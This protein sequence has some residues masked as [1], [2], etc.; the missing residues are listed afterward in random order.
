MSAWQSRSS[1]AAFALLVGVAATAAAQNKAPANKP[2]P[3]AAETPAAGEEAA[4]AP[5]PQAEAPEPEG[6]SIAEATLQTGETQAELKK[7]E[8]RLEIPPTVE[9]VRKDVYTRVL[10]LQDARRAAEQRLGSGEVQAKGLLDLQREWQLRQKDTGAWRA[11]LRDYGSEIDAVLQALDALAK[12]W[13][14]TRER[15]IEAEADSVVERVDAIL[16]EIAD[17]EQIAR[18]RLAELIDIQDRTTGMAGVITGVLESVAT[19]EKEARSRVFQA[20]E[21]PFWDVAAAHSPAASWQR[22]QADFA[23]DW[24]ALTTYIMERRDHAIAHLLFVLTTLLG[25]GFLGRRVRA[26]AE[27]EPQLAE[28]ATVLRDPV[29]IAVLVGVATARWFYPL[30]PGA[31]NELM[32]FLLLIPALTLL[33]RIV[34]APLRP[35]VLALA[36]FYLASQLRNSLDGAPLLYRGL[37]IAELA[38]GL[39]FLIWL[40]R[41][42]RL[43]KIEHPEQLP[44][45]LGPLA[46]L[47]LV[48]F[49][50]ALVAAILGY[51]TFASLLAQGL[52][53]SAYTAALLY[54]LYRALCALLLAFLHTSFAR[55]LRAIRVAEDR[56]H[57]FASRVLRIGAVIWWAGRTLDAFGIQ[58]PVVEALVAAAG[59]HITLGSVTIS[60]GDVLLFLTVAAGSFF[61]SRF[62]RFFLEEDVFPRVVLRR[63]VSNAISTTVHYSILLGGFL[64]AVA[65]AGMDLSRLTL[66]AGA[67]GVGIGFGLQNIVNNFVSG[68]ILLFERPIQV[69]DTIE[70]VGGLTGDVRRI[71]P[72]SSTVRTFDGAEVIV[73]NAMLVSDQVTNWTLSDRRRRIKVGVGVK[74][75][76]DPERVLELL[77]EV[78]TENETVLEDPKPMPIFLGFGDSSLDFELRCWIPRYEEG[79][80]MTTAL[81]TAINAKLR[82][83][84]IEIPF[85]QRDLHLRSVDEPARE[86]LEEIGA[87]APQ[88]GIRLIPDE[89]GSGGR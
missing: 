62:V 58:Q 16:A 41:P 6:F 66:L 7:L 35:V 60:L 1:V 83:D 55:K 11:T 88:R 76:T 17:V 82:D 59:S 87:E 79:F 2:A 12:P 27:E 29:S 34:D 57:G 40:N 3:A 18:E 71:G 70:V 73:P 24:Q 54:A 67:F 48:T 72:R 89:G 22:V 25:A 51:S 30:A 84:G 46:R 33:P 36:F 80:G 5:A 9:A 63:G 23:R 86:A 78:A 45:W 32:G 42:A 52:L 13:K 69:G 65:A 56:V 31:L 8:K 10:S 61:L 64:L 15:A 74:Y 49:G 53:N 26:W 38:L 28:T 37:Q 19:L 85:P 50:V 4:P 47:A 20:D 39:A 43:A 81:L 68:L 44:G 77:R 21:V 75:G 14:A